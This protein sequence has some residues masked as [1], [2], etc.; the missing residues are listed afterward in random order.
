MRV[1]DIS[2]CCCVP[3]KFLLK[4][5]SLG[6]LEIEHKTFV[7]VDKIFQSSGALAQSCDIP[8]LL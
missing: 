2:S 6:Y 4:V 1:K 5:Q 8:H 3:Y 7:C